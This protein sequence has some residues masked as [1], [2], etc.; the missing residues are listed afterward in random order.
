MVFF[1]LNYPVL[2]G[3]ELLLLDKKEAFSRDTIYSCSDHT[4]FEDHC[5]ALSEAALIPELKTDK[6]L[7][8]PRGLDGT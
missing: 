6:K 7:L 3:Q 2:S 1:Y 4:R 5:L 8:L